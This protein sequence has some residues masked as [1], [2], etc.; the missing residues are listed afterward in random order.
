MPVKEVDNKNMKDRLTP[1]M[2]DRL[3][4]K[5]KEDRGQPWG[6]RPRGPETRSCNN[7]HQVGHLANNCSAPP[8]LPG[9]PACPPA[10]PFAP[11]TDYSKHKTEG[12]VCTSCKKTGHV[13]NQCW[14]THP[15]LIPPDQLKRR[16]G[17]M[18]SILRKRMRAAEDTSLD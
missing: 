13:A 16:Q 8:L 5:T 18:A 10:I 15:E 9:P 1:R 12:A 11:R 2:E 7:C 6:E 17:A 4:P 14:A 3:G